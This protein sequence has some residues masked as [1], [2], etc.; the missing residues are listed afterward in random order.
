MSK[1]FADEI[2]MPCAIVSPHY[3]KIY[4]EVRDSATQESKGKLWSAGCWRR[5][6]SQTI[7]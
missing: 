4:I 7:E 2:L 5:D 6:Q 3:A 1:E